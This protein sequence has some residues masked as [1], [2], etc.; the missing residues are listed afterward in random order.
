MS[1]LDKK[2]QN[3]LQTILCKYCDYTTSR[4]IIGIDICIPK[5]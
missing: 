4:K 2:E 1:P 3:E 5:T